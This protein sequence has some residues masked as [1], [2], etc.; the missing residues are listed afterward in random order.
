MRFIL[1]AFCMLYLTSSGAA[2]VYR[3]EGT[4]LDSQCTSRTD[5]VI[6]NVGVDGVFTAAVDAVPNS[7][8]GR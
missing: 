5:D 7:L 3:W 8:P 6:G 4:C 1:A 2:T